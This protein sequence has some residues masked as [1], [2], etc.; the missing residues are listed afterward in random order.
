MQLL[1][2]SVMSSIRPIEVRDVPRVYLLENCKGGHQ[3]LEE[4]DY[5]LRLLAAYSTLTREGKVG[6]M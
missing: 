2:A 5:W 4:H 6:K 3:R 1:R